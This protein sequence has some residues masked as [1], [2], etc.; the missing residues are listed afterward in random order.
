VIQNSEV[1]ILLPLGPR[2]L[3]RQCA[4]LREASRTQSDQPSN[5]SLWHWSQ[6]NLNSELQVS[7]GCIGYPARP[8]LVWTTPRQNSPYRPS[9][10]CKKHS[11]LK[12]LHSQQQAQ[13]LE[14]ASF[15]LSRLA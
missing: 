6:G 3:R 2:S 13:N 5:S 10:L 12:K 14:L 1:C 7:S 4:P 11:T 8:L 9:L 15:E